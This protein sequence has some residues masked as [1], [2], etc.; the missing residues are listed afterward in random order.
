MREVSSRPDHRRATTQAPGRR[1]ASRRA[2]TSL[3]RISFVYAGPCTRRS[4]DRNIVV[5]WPQSDNRSLGA[6]SES[7]KR[8]TRTSWF[9]GRNALWERAAWLATT[10]PVC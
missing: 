8:S 7:K 2:A 3:G 5:G 1:S 4:R 9:I 10:S 6:A